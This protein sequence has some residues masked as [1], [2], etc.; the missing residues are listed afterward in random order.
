MKRGS[1]STDL[2]SDTPPDGFTGEVEPPAI[3]EEIA[4][5]PTRLQ[6]TGDIAPPP[7]FDQ[8]VR[9]FNIFQLILIQTG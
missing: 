9:I 8:A 7:E 2:V 5:Q 3:P 6:T 4:Q 1:R